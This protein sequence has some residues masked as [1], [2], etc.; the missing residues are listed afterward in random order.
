[1]ARIETRGRARA[2]QALYAWDV[3]K[4]DVPLPRV[5]QLVW[6][7]LGTA[8]EERAF[9]HALIQLIDADRANMDAELSEV[10]TN[11]RLERLGHIERCVLRLGAAELTQGGTPPRVVIQECVRLAER[12]GSG[13]SAR[14]V[15][16]VLDALARRMGRL[17]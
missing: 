12:F 17:S 10:T 9:A 14:F 16:G 8:P 11:W 4:D 5:A 1:M 13:Q 2:L 3:R 6:D 15:N 7:D